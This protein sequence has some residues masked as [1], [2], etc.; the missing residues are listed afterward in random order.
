M[1]DIEVFLFFYDIMSYFLF[2]FGLYLCF[3]Y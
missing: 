3:D 1:L 2:L